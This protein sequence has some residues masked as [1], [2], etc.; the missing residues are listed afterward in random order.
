MDP[1]RRRLLIILGICE[2]ALLFFLIREIR[3]L[4]DGNLHVHFLDVGQ[5][6]SILLRSPSGKQIL[7]DGGPNDRVIEQLGTRMSFFD[8]SL[9][10]VVLTHPDHDHSGGLPAVLRRYRVDKL[11]IT[12]IVKKES[13]YDDILVLAKQKKIPLFIADPAQDITLGDGVTLDLIWPPATLAGTEVEAANETSVVMRVSFHAK[14]ILFTGDIEAGAERDILASG[15]D[16]DADVLKVAH[17]GSK[18]SSA[19]GFLLAVSPD[20]AIISVARKNGYGH[21][22]PSVM[23]RF[24][25]FGIPTRSTALE[26]T[27]DL[28]IP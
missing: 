17:H 3:L 5:G 24:R 23:D 11:L 10:M 14:S 26:G 4:P 22:H 15:A 2:L 19:T 21:P 18:T 25:H 9:D 1:K 13:A 16:I 6:D 8:R 20:L 27:I 28:T 7:I 12:G